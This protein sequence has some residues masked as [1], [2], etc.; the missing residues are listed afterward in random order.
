M[1]E[2]LKRY[3]NAKPLSQEVSSTNVRVEG[4]LPRELGGVFVQ[5]GPDAFQP[6]ASQFYHPFESDGMLH[7]LRIGGTEAT[8]SAKY[9]K[10]RHLQRDLTTG[11]PHA[12]RLMDPVAPVDLDSKHGA[13]PYRNP[14][15]T[16]TLAFGH[17]LFALHEFGSAY[18][19]DPTTLETIGAVEFTGRAG[20]A[21]T[22]H[23]RRD[24][25]TGEVWYARASLTAKPFCVLGCLDAHGAALHECAVPFEQPTL[26][27]DFALTKCFL[28]VCEQPFHFNSRTGEWTL[29]SPLTT[30]FHVVPRDE[31]AR[32]VGHGFAR[33]FQSPT[34]TFVSHFID[35]F[36]D[37]EKNAII[38]RG[39]GYGQLPQFLD[40]LHGREP[41]AADA[42][43]QSLGELMLWEFDLDTGECRGK[44]LCAQAAEFPRL[45][46]RHAGT[47]HRYVYFMGHAMGH[48]FSKCDLESGD[49]HT[50]PLGKSIQ[51]G[52]CLFIPKENAQAEDD[53]YLAGFTYDAFTRTS[54]WLAFDAQNSGSPPVVRISLQSRVPFGF[55]AQWYPRGQFSEFSARHP[56]TSSGA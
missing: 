25:L 1:K 2:R 40:F 5:I 27:H 49:V 7:V 18:E 26:V 50:F 9:V 4:C 41:R 15:N 56:A 29:R 33:V 12:Y 13:F 30:R 6:S 54:Q 22:G 39:I 44:S 14:A 34:P 17:R 31:K 28:V 45:N 10:T 19:I 24:L 51:A 20:V 52:E 46:E 21:F 36:E 55:H 53:G 8:Y 42:D 37:R 3:G 38:V 23:P 35:A 43:L 11:V 47:P 48:A 16:N 32:T